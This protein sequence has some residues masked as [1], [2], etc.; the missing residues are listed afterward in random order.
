[1][2]ATWFLPLPLLLA[3]CAAPGVGPDAVPRTVTGDWGGP[4]VGLRLHADGGAIEYDCANGTL[5]A[6]LVVDAT[7]AFRVA[8]THV[9]GHGGPARQGEVLPVE[10]ATYQGTVR[11]DRMA[12]EVR[13]TS[14]APATYALQRGAPAQ[15]FKCL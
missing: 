10:P 9:R 6:P 15:V 4:H 7:G 2:R 14:M 5:D 8:G 3:A 1:M 13:T 12:L 11:G